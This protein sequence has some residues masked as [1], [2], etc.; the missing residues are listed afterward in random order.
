[1]SIVGEA[2]PL[3]IVVNSRLS[4]LTG[5]GWRVL[6]ATAR[7][8]HQNEGPAHGAKADRG[9][10]PFPARPPSQL[11]ARIGRGMAP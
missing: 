7:A 9:W 6:A 3:T 1:M 5:D 2:Q 8:S 11:S 4:G 10:F